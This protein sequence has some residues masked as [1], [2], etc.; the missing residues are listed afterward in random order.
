MGLHIVAST[1]LGTYFRW[2]AVR[3]TPLPVQVQV[4]YYTPFV[5]RPQTAVSCVEAE[6]AADLL[7]C[8]AVQGNLMDQCLTP[9]QDMIGDFLS[10][11]KN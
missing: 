7:L 4:F 11:Y 9:L 1:A 5:Q 2:V 10:T 3:V 8:T 6:P